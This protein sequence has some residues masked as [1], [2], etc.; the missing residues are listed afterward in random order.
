MH[1]A[2][3]DLTMTDSLLT[4]IP[5]RGRI[6]LTVSAAERNLILRLRSLRDRPRLVWLEVTVAG[7]AIVA[8][9][10]TKREQMGET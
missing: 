10:E 8:M 6:T 3:P 5:E 7:L 2:L 1:A 4:P 9:F